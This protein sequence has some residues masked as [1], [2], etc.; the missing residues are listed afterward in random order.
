VG[1]SSPHHTTPPR[2][3]WERTTPLVD[4]Y[5][6][7]GT[8]IPFFEQVRPPHDQSE[9]GLRLAKKMQVGPCIRVGIQPYTG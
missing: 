4:A 6:V 9:Q 1:A 7:A 3:A 5:A 8:A 2:Q